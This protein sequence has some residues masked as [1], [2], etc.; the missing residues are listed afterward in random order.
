[1]KEKERIDRMAAAKQ[2]RRFLKPVVSRDPK[3][4]KH[5]SRAINKI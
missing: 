3:F 2:C 4:K 1:M 5:S